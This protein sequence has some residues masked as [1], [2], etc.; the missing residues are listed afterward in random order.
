MNKQEALLVFSIS[1]YFVAGETIQTLPCM[2]LCLIVCGSVC[3]FK[4]ARLALGCCTVEY[5]QL[6]MS[7]LRVNTNQYEK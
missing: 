5:K 7:A 4:E 3:S 1:Q 6:F 2:C